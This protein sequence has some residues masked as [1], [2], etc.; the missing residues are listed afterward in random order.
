M[1]TSL[2]VAAAAVL[3]APASAWAGAQ[4][5]N[6]YASLFTAQLNGVSPEKPAPPRAPAPV[7]L[8]QPSFSAPAQTVVCG[9]TIVQGNSKLDPKMP[10]KLPAGAPKGAIQVMPAPACGK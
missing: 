9:L 7:P 1:R 4:P 5:R 3:L 6:P 2:L 10:R 8:P